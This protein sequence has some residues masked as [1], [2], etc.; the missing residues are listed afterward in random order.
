MAGGVCLQKVLGRIYEQK[1]LFYAVNMLRNNCKTDYFVNSK[2]VI[3]EE[4]TSAHCIQSKPGELELEV[5][6]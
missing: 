1:G 6:K 5:T 3:R 2:Q 4:E